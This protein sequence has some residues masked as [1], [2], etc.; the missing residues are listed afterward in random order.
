[1]LELAQEDRGILRQLTARFD[2]SAA[3]DELVAATRRAIADATDFDE[4]EMNRNFDYDYAA[5]EEVKRNLARLITSGQVRLAMQ[6]SLELMKQGSHQVE[7]SD[8]GLMTD[9][10]E[11]CLSVVLQGLK[12]C[13]LPADEIIAVLGDARQRSRGIHRP[14]PASIAAQPVPN[15]DSA[16]VGCVVISKT[17][18]GQFMDST[19]SNL[20]VALYARVSSEGRGNAGFI[21][22][23]LAKLRQRIA[24]ETGSLD[25]AACFVDKGVSGTSPVRP[26]LQRLREQAAHGAFD[27]LYVLAP[28]R[29]ARSRASLAQLIGEFTQAG[30]EV[31]FLDQ[32]HVDEREYED[33]R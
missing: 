19:V 9:D 33:E 6:L 8:E 15:R 5:Y 25:D 17:K 30:V 1:L 12:K 14:R 13:D 29:L 11:D 28:D 20:R 26:A 32:A 21:G 2:V 4:R 16:K 18:G 24:Q 7:M 22:R 23:Q 27:R 31:A 10:I 3:P